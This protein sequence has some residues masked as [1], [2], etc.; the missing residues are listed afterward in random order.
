LFNKVEDGIEQHKE[1]CWS[2]QH[3]QR[4]TCYSNK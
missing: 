2:A 1:T 4:W 3:K